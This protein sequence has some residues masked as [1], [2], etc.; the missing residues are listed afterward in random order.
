MERILFLTNVDHGAAEA[1]TKLMADN[2]YEAIVRCSEE[3]WQED[4][5]D[6]GI[7]LVI[8]S[9]QAPLDYL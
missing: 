1:M 4:S 6:D 8:I 9:Q 7:T 2:G 5:L 3:D